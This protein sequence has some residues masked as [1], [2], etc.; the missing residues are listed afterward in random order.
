MMAN[1]PDE[2]RNNVK[3]IKRAFDGID[4]MSTLTGDST[5]ETASQLRKETIAELGDFLQKL[6]DRVG[7]ST[8]INIA[9]TEECAKTIGRMAELFEMEEFF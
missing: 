1:N 7:G 9:N 3:A 4:K 8:F 2:L 5:I 6:F